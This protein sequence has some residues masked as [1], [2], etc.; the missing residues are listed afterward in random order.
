MTDVFDVFGVFVSCV[1]ADPSLL[2]MFL[3]IDL[4]FDVNAKEKNINIPWNED[5]IMN[6]YL[7]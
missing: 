4:T 2:T 5:K 7:R 6:P 3:H 1:D